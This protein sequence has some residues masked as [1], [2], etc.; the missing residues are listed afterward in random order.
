MSNAIAITR[1][2]GEAPKISPM[3]LPDGYAQYA[4]NAKLTSGDLVPYRQGKKVLDVP[5]SVSN[6]KTIFPMLLNST[7]YWNMWTSDVDIARSVIA[8]ITTQRIN[9]SGDG[10]P[11]TTDINRAAFPTASVGGDK[12]ANYTQV[13]TD[14]ESTV[15]FTA[16]PFTFNLLAV[17]TAK[18]QFV[19]VVWNAAGSGNITVDPAGAELINGAATL[20]VAPG[21]IWLLKCDGTAWSGVKKTNYPYDYFDLGVAAPVA[22]PT[23]AY[24]SLAKSAGYTTVAG[25]SGR[26]IDC[27]STPWTLTL[28][29]AATM[30]STFIIVVRNLGTG[31]LTVNCTG[32]QLINGVAS[33]TLNSGEITVITCNGTSF[34]GTSL[35]SG[36]KSYVYTYVTGWGEESAPSPASNILLHTSGQQINVTG[37]PT[38][39][40]AGAN[41]NV[42]KYRLY[43]TN[44]GTTGTVYQLVTEQTIGAGT[45]TYLDSVTNSNLSTVLPS[46]LWL[47]PPSDL[48]GFVTMANGMMAGFHANEVCFCEPYKP[49]AWPLS[50]RYSVDS[51]IVSIAAIANSLVITTTGRPA[52]ATGNHPASVTIYPIDLPYPCTSKRGMVNIG[53]GVMYPSFE[54]LVLVTGASP[55]L[56]T[57]QL[58]TRT[59]WANFYPATLVARFFDGKYFANY[60][61]AD[62]SLGSFIFQ[63]ASDR[64]PLF[65]EANIVSSTAYSDLVTGYYYYVYNNVLYQWDE[66]TMPYSSVDWWSKEYEFNKPVN[67]GAAK[68]EVTFGS[69]GSSAA[70]TVAANTAL[71]A[72]GLDNVGGF[73]G[74]SELGNIEM[75]ADNLSV[76]TGTVEAVV[77]QLYTNGALR[78][79]KTVY[80]NK[81]FRLPLGFKADRQ[82]FRISGPVKIHALLVA[83][84]PQA[85]ERISGA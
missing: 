52:I 11:K 73:L 41:L 79:T 21:E 56:A 72:S 70:Q 39:P 82:S 71:I 80:D 35:T 76:V 85:L 16:A 55:V 42:T 53:T 36:F 77:F 48:Q 17:A 58:F 44:T 60:T 37:L 3:L 81:V 74:D 63:A 83:E 26:T 20:T 2:G 30:T 67:F 64:V 68:L 18:N 19:T 8:N 28:G 34:A 84:T 49:H 29:D 6:P 5:T 57:A 66:A 61:K 65:V 15:K 4:L 32:G 43:R 27:T 40:P 69:G 45:G 59:E 62:G 9:Y 38:S 10:A 78:F 46:A 7:Y 24:N 75:A 50:Y 31:V 33:A 23:M 54:G 1:F 12:T 13:A 51:P 25:D 22:A 14:L 47:T